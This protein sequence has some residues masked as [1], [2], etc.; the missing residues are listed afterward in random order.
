MARIRLLVVDD[1]E[2]ILM[3]IRKLIERE[4][5]IEIVGEARN[6]RAALELARS[7][8]PDVI[9]MD[10]RMP[11]M[12]GVAA[13]RA[14]MAD[15]PV[16][17]V[18][19]SALTQEGAETTLNAMAA[20]AVDFL[21]KVN[22]ASSTDMVRFSAELLEKIRAWGRRGAR[23][24]APAPASARP[25]RTLGAVRMDL[26]A[27]G[28]STGGPDA[29]RTLLECCGRLRAPMVIAQHMPAYFTGAFAKAL[30]RDTGL[31]VREGADGMEI[32]AGTVTI[33]PGGRDSVLEMAGAG[34]SRIGPRQRKERAGSSQRRSS[35]RDRGAGRPLG[36][37]RDSHRHGPRRIA[38]GG[39]L[40]S[41]GLPCSCAGTVLVRGW[42]HAVIGDRGRGGVTRS[43]P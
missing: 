35:I 3:V 19:V 10:V 9:T 34:R 12:D 25:L 42:R 14:L 20:G 32:E 27:V 18:M 28:V 31:T 8:K 4:A 40:R 39:L 5:D 33:L 22:G 11:D 2:F 30:A 43:Y 17:V 7:L 15:C 21:A 41:K 6:G 16:P 29:V 37:R 1:S 24:P 13:T 36:G 38:R 23:K 26:I